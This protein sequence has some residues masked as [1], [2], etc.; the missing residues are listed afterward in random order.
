ME[1]LA[2]EKGLAAVTLDTAEEAIGMARQLMQ[3][4]IGAY[5]QGRTETSAPSAQV[6]P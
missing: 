5:M 6:T 3:E 1:N 2:R 4:T